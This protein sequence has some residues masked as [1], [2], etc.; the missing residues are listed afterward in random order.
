MIFTNFFGWKN[1]LILDFAVV[2]TKKE[3]R[4]SIVLKV[5]KLI[6]KMF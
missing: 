6:P 1:I 4:F 2:T 5:F 3:K